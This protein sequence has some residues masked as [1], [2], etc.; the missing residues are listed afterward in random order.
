MKIL[1]VASFDGNIGDRANHAGFYR[2]FNS[3]IS[4]NFHVEQMEIRDFYKAWALKKFDENFAA[5]ANQHDLLIFGGGAF[6]EPRWD[7]SATGT[8]IDL[9]DE[10]LTA[11]SVPVLFN[12]IG[13]NRYRGAT[14][15]AV[16]KFRQ[17][18]RR[19]TSSNQFFTSVRNDGSM[20]ELVAL[21]GNE[22]EGKIHKVPDGGYFIAPEPQKQLAICEGKI[23]IAIVLGGDMPEVRFKESENSI[24][25]QEFVSLFAA[26]CDKLLRSDDNI[27][28]VFV[29]H[30]YADLRFIHQILDAMNEKLV[31]TKVTVAALLNGSATDGLHIFDLYR[32][33]ALV[34]GMRHH[35]TVCAVGMNVPTLGLLNYS[36]HI[37]DYHEIGLPHRYVRADR[38]DFDKKLESKIYEALYNPEKFRDENAQAMYGVKNL[39]L[40]YFSKMKEWLE[41]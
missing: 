28:L 24:R 13:V 33:C 18:L 35:A 34:I 40:A 11:I 25:P 30:I 26:L 4:Q 3:F 37:A 41:K 8:T 22:F 2:S 19:V 38:K 6:W 23:H 9:A 27:R 21:F 32:H 14:E 20:D 12:G 39:N 31:R 16:A 10:V 36:S 15:N 29:P 17:F 1:H 5:L 7:Y